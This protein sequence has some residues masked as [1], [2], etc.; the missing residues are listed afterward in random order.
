MF[1]ASISA[2]SRLLE[3]VSIRTSI[4]K[5]KGVKS[6]FN[7]TTLNFG[8]FS[9]LVVAFC[10]SITAESALVFDVMVSFVGL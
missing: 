1:T 5:S 9:G 8:G 3:K 4:T 6:S 2:S 10:F 7:K